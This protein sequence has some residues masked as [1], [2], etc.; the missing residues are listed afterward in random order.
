[1][2]S[3]HSLCQQFGHIL[4]GEP[5][6]EHGVCSVSIKRNLRVTI[7]GRPSK[8]VGMEEVMFE[9]LDQNGTALNMAEV[10]ILPEEIPLFTKKLV[11]QGII[12]SA[13]H[14][15]WIFTKPNILYIHFQSVEPPLT[16]ARKTAA[17][18][19]VLR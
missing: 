11:D 5:H 4:N 14:N 3:F 8:G 13:L 1:M 17:A 16:F 15:H 9:S 10:A 19:S 12:I 6:I 18:L 2:Q 7:Q